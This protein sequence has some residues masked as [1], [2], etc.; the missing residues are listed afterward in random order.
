MEERGVARG[1]VG[2]GATFGDRNHDA[3]N[4]A[5]Y[6]QRQAE[7]RPHIVDAENDPSEAGCVRE[8]ALHVQQI[9]LS[10]TRARA[11]TT[12]CVRQELVHTPKEA[13]HPSPISSLT[14]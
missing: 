10:E 4:V 11:A 8:E 1:V 13:P 12:L 9:Q 6:S 7:L 3:E 14:R 2:C 5:F